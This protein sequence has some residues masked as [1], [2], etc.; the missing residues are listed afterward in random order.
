VLTSLF[1]A[2]VVAYVAAAVSEFI[3]MEA[4]DPVLTD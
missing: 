2:V 3:A 1:I 4:E